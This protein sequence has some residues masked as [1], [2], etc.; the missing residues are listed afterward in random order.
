MQAVNQLPHPFFN[1][2]SVGPGLPTRQIVVTRLA[3]HYHALPQE[4]LSQSEEK[5][6]V[7]AQ[8]PIKP[9]SAN[10]YGNV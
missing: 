2:L 5:R 10:I 8:R 1:A 4:A 9:I 3:N 7:R 6:E